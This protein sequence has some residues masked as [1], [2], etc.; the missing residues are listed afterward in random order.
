M[1]TKKNN[2]QIHSNE[3][4][5]EFVLDTLFLRIE[6]CKS[7]GNVLFYFA[8]Q[9]TK[10]ENSSVFKK[11]RRN[12]ERG[13]MHTKKGLCM[14]PDLSSEFVPANKA[15]YSFRLLHGC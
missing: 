10:Q 1:T 12:G 2:L 6:S 4:L 11:I 13:N 15:H 3:F 14:T 7:L 5:F 9:E 8:L